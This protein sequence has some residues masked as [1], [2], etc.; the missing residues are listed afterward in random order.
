MIW[1]QR[2]ANKYG[3]RK[4]LYNGRLYD[5]G[6]EATVAQEID[7]RKKAG[8]VAAVEPQKAFP[9]FAKNGT[10]VCTHRVDFLL[11]FKD[12]H[13]EAWEAK[14]VATSIWNLKKKLF[15]DNYPNIPYIVVTTKGSWYE[16]HST[17]SIAGRGERG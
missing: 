5:S 15:L 3:A 7:L 11:T 16:T 4:T 13:Q 8:E 1:Y 6:L 17:P 14:G 2:P 9:L 12:G 10:K